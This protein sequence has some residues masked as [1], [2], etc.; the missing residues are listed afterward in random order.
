MS[1]HTDT[2]EYLYTFQDNGETFTAK[3]TIFDRKEI[4]GLV[5]YWLASKDW[6]HIDMGIYVDLDVPIVRIV[7]L[8]PDREHLFRATRL[9]PVDGMGDN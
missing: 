7:Q 1:S 5:N 4:G 6:P 8:S 9:L 3:V 2:R